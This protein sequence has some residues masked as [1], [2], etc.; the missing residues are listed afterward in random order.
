MTGSVMDGGDIVQ[1]ALF[2]AYRKLDTFE[3]GRPLR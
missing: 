2:Q 3:D 1:D